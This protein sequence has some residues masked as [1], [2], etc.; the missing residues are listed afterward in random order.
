MPARSA[1]KLQHR[2]MRHAQIVKSGRIQLL[3]NAAMN[4]LGRNAQQC[5]DENILRFVPRTFSR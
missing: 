3:D 2:D 4:R 1:R 5:A